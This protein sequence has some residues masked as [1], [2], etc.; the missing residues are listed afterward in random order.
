MVT[1]VDIVKEQIRIAARQP[2]S[3]RDEDVMARGHAIE[4][5][6]NAEDAG[7]GFA[8]SPGVVGTY[9]E[10][11]G[12]GIRVDSAMEPGGE[13]SAAYDSLIAKLIAWGR[14]RD[15]AIARM[16]RA[17][18]DFE[19]GGVPTTIPFHRNVM[20]DERF[21][22]GQL[23]T[24]F[25]AEAPD[26]I[27]SPA[28]SEPATSVGVPS[29]QEVI[30]EVNGR[31]F[32]VRLPEAFAASDNGRTRPAAARRPGAPS[33]PGGAVGGAGDSGETLTSP[34]QGTVLRVPAEAGQ[35]V[36]R[37]DVICIVEAMKMENELVAHRD[38][39]IAELRVAP[40]ATLRIRDVVAV[41]R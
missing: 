9:R 40:G 5:R 31:R 8:P 30:A 24:T 18:A 36:R 11:S 15:E 2:I 6:V 13:I 20:G 3:F 39:T 12:F 16:R 26:L 17:L 29:W 21:R 10:P 35:A 7:R 41:I 23:A 4:C 1:G 34:I 25:L 32:V 28:D 22:A 14:D 38:G 37:G 27:P 19:I 33:G